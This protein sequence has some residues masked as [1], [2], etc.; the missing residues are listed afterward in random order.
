MFPY[1]L[2]TFLFVLMGNSGIG[3]ADNLYLWPDTNFASEENW[4]KGR[5]PCAGEQLDLS[6]SSYPLITP[7]VPV[8]LN[9][10]SGTITLPMSTT[11]V[12]EEGFSLT[13]TVRGEPPR[14]CA[15]E[16]S[17]N[18]FIPPSRREW[19][20]PGAWCTFHATSFSS[21]GREGA[22]WTIGSVGSGSDS[23][24][25]SPDESGF[26]SEAVWTRDAWRGGG[27]RSECIQSG[28]LVRSLT[29]LLLLPC[30]HDSALLPPNSTVLLSLTSSLGK[31]PEIG[32]LFIGSTSHTSSSFGSLLNTEMGRVQFEVGLKSPRPLTINVEPS[33][34]P[35]CLRSG[36]RDLLS[37][38]SSLCAR[39]NL[40]TCSPNTK[41]PDS[42]LLYQPVGACC[43][44]CGDRTIVLQV[45]VKYG[46]KRKGGANGP[47]RVLDLMFALR[48]LHQ[49]IGEAVRNASRPGVFLF[50][51]ML[52]ASCFL[53]LITPEAGGQTA[54]NKDGELDVK[55][56]LAQTVASLYS[57]LRP[58]E[59]RDTAQRLDVEY[60]QVLIQPPIIACIHH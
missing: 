42:K 54:L 52:N 48:S 47:M 29:P 21:P 4:S 20:D 19:L 53:V 3:L 34:C 17:P 12:L 55:S 36:C 50:S 31:A 28:A 40:S 49:S 32:Q 33:R 1:F 7:D 25:R 37:R 59:T 43:P 44:L 51:R 23:K 14:K 9:A 5:P 2:A 57:N 60:I 26:R 56:P 13:S 6:S 58:L 16:P 11:I 35:S 46:L 45:H 38:T 10:N 24:L 30:A 22:D 27:R 18:R 39:Y 15:S 41:C 8:E